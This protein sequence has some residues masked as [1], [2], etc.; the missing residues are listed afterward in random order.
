MRAK[1]ATALEARFTEAPRGYQLVMV[2]IG[3]PHCP[4]VGETRR[5]LMRAWRAYYL[6]NNRR[7]GRF[8]YIGTHEITPGSDGLGHPHAHVVCLWPVGKPGDG[9]QGDWE[10]Q[11]KLWLEA[12]PTSTRINFTASRHVH[13]AARYI[14]KYVSKGVQTDEF[15]PDLRA[16]VLAGTYNTRWMFTSHR[17]WVPFTPCCKACGVSVTRADVAWHGRCNT[18][19]AG[20][21]WNPVPRQADFWADD[22]PDENWFLV[23]V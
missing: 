14:S 6:A 7:W 4:D 19:D 8:V 22:R 21:W 11:R 20:W 15:T 3:L 9:T 5:E 12:A 16:R 1:I 18:P 2:T 10:L 17:V 13:K 23:E